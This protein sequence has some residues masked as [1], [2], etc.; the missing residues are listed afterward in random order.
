[1]SKLSYLPI[2][3]LARSGVTES[4][5]YG[6]VSVVNAQGKLLAWYGN[7][8]VVTFLRSAAKPFQALP[9]IDSVGHETINL[10][11]EEIAIICA[12]HSG[13]DQHVSV[14]KAIQSKIGLSEA[15]LNCGI[16]PP[17]HKPTA[18]KLIERGIEPSAIHNN[19][20]GK[21]TGMLAL[22]R[23][24]NMPTSDYIDTDHP[25]QQIILKTFSEMCDL[26]PQEIGLGIDG[27]SVPTFAIPLQNVSFAYARLCDPAELS[28]RRASSCRTITSAMMAHPEMVAGPGRF[29]TRL[30]QVAQGRII[31]KGGA[32]G[33]QGLGLLPGA[34]NPNSPGIGIAIK[35]ADGDKAGRAR[36]AVALEVLHQIG[37]LSTN[38]LEKLGDFGI[39]RNLLNWRDIVVGKSRPCFTLQMS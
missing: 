20:S 14:V 35:I 39:T 32:E 4:A 17:I 25:V 18:R 37:A 36:S 22:A 38:E 12:S 7:P 16:H 21:H 11:Q 28:I 13:T 19:C 10:T 1:M 24:Q 9:L 30:M 8:L 15:D 3:E 34:L 33:F 6:S 31:A 29:D 23:I 27:C 26:N 5:H 2:L